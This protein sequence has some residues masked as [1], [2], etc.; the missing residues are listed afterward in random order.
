V[1]PQDYL[2]AIKAKLASSPTVVRIHVVQEYATPSQ[3][4]FRARLTLRNDEFLEVVDT[5]GSAADA[6]GLFATGHTRTT[7]PHPRGPHPID[8]IDADLR[9]AGVDQRPIFA[10]VARRERHPIR[11]VPKVVMT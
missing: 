6:P 2:A 9:F 4:F 1:D 10:H 8:I 11:F 3:G 7:H 5:Y